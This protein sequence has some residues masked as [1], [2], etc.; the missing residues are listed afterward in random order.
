QAARHEDG[1]ATR[2]A[3][4]RLAR[5][6]DLDRRHRL[7]RIGVHGHLSSLLRYRARSNRAV[8]LITRTKLIRTN[9]SAQARAWSAGSGD[10]AR[11]KMSIAIA[12]EPFQAA[13]P[14][15]ITSRAKTKMPMMIEGSPLRT[16]STSL[17]ASAIPGD[18]N[19]LT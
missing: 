18:A 6:S 8:R 11:A 1:F 16:S 14:L 19:S 9:P 13:C 3:Q 5:L 7:H 4:R 10:S 2:G 15:P 12:N 17:A